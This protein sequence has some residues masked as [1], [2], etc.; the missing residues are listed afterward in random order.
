MA[1]GKP[2]AYKFVVVIP[3][4]E[5]EFKAASSSNPTNDFIAGGNLVLSMLCDETQTVGLFFFC[6]PSK[7]TLLKRKILNNQAA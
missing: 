4:L 7:S 6:L 2:F 3:L 5:I 1:T